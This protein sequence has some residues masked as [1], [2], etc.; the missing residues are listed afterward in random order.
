[1]HLLNEAAIEKEPPKSPGHAKN[2]LVT[3]VILLEKKGMLKEIEKLTNIE[4][5]FKEIIQLV[6]FIDESIKLQEITI[7]SF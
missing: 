6:Y 5:V 3:T 2:Q 7:L 4:K 1:M